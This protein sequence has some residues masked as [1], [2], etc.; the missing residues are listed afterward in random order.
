MARSSTMPLDDGK[1]VSTPNAGF[2]S[3]SLAM[4]L[5]SIKNLT[6]SGQSRLSSLKKSAY[7]GGW[8][9]TLSPSSKKAQEAL[10]HGV[11]SVK[12]AYFTAATTVSKRVEEFREYQTP[13]KSMSPAVSN[14][15][16][17]ARD[18]DA[19]SQVVFIFS[20]NLFGI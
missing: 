8:S 17:S 16:L 14:Q 3:P 20:S 4:S 1:Q 18:E 7:F 6:K 13:Q 10:T 5:S 11:M 15:Y 19:M 12:S 9:T 2:A